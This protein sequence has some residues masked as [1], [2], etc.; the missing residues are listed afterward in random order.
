MNKLPLVLLQAHKIALLMEQDHHPAAGHYTHLTYW[1][2]HRI[3]VTMSEKLEFSQFFNIARKKEKMEA[4]LCNIRDFS[5]D[6]DS[7]DWASEVLEEC[8][9]T[10]P[11]MPRDQ[12]PLPAPAAVSLKRE[13][14]GHFNGRG[15][16]PGDEESMERSEE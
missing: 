1:L 4:V 6:D 7:R 13:A 15:V 10:S 14:Y 11:V 3:G 16:L 2:A 12:I 5:K 8:G 9:C